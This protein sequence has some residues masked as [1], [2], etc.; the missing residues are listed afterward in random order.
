MI[1]LGSEAKGGKRGAGGAVRG[2]RVAL[3]VVK[4]SFAFFTK[5]E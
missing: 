3:G 1:W 4:F 5:S 2:D